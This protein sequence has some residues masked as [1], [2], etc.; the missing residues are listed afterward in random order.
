MK[1]VEKKYRAKHIDENIFLLKEGKTLVKS[2]KSNGKNEIIAEK[3]ILKPLKPYFNYNSVLEKSFAEF[4][5][6]LIEK[7]CFFIDADNP[8]FSRAN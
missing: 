8:Q 1:P 2:Y 7:E 5:A 4:A 6:P 3:D